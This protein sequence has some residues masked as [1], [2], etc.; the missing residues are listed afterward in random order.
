MDIKYL[1]TFLKVCELKS[2]TLAAERLGLTQ[3]GVSKQMQRIEA[4]LNTPLFCRDD[5]GLSLTD[6]GRHLHQTARLLVS[7]WALLQNRVHQFDGPLQGTLRIGASSIPTKHFLPRILPAFHNDCPAVQVV[8]RS[9]DSEQV[10]DLLQ[11]GD[12]DVALLGSK[13]ESAEIASIR[14]AAD[15]LVIVAN[16][17]HCS[18][19]TWHSCPFILRESGSGTRRAAEEALRD[20]GVSP[21]GLSST[22]Q[23]NDTSLMLR[24]VASGLG[25]AIVSN[26]DASDAVASG[27]VQ[28]V[29][30]LTTA[31]YFH[32]AYPRAEEYTPL[33]QAFLH[34]ATLHMAHS[35][36]SAYAP[37]LARSP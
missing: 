16:P 11:K 10:L 14:I 3:P 7:E 9:H 18:T 25:L 29:H 4:E 27:Q 13:P 8:V 34:T 5:H 35:M 23:T 15:R 19:S 31:R 12:I 26:L 30:E 2:F 24:M 17:D 1:D 6:A 28:V 37:P 21:E 20:M 22:L 32:I 33:L 36:D